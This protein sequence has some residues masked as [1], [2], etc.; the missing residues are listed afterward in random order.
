M[1]VFIKDLEKYLAGNPRQEEILGKARELATPQNGILPARA[2]YELLG[3]DDA[4]A[5]F[6]LRPRR[7]NGEKHKRA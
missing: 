1:P 5:F 2:V 7:Q 3:K 4:I 6:Q